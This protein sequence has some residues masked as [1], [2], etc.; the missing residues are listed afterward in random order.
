MK[1]IQ[2]SD[3]WVLPALNEMAIELLNQDIDSS[4]NVVANKN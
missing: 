3:L 4:F 2:I 1:K